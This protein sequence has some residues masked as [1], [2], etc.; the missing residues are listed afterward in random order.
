MRSVL[1]FN[2]QAGTADRIKD[3]LLHLTSGTRCELRPTGS[4]QD[5]RRF[6]REAV[7][8]GI[9]RLI[10]AG[11][12]GTI[13]LAIEGIAPH[14][15][16][17]ELAVLPFGTGNDLARSLGFTPDQMEQAYEAA[18]GPHTV[19]IDIIRI[20]EKEGVQHCINVANGGFGGRVALDV[21]SIDKRRWGP[22]AYWITSASRLVDLQPYEV[23]MELDGQHDEHISSFGVAIANGRFVGGGFPIAPQALLDDGWM[24]ITVIPVLPTIELMVAGL[25]FTLNPQSE[26][27]IRTFRAR[28]LRFDSTPEMPFSVDGEP[29]RHMS[30]TCETLPRV[31]RVVASKE[32]PGLSRTSAGSATESATK[33]ATLPSAEEE[34]DS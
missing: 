23:R 28:R 33:T 29:I 17:I 31:L 24:D 8:E 26:E 3:F 9:D 34:N 22:M 7:E 19:P 10:V 14:F 6:A 16:R 13:G 32:A 12:D 5:A 18:F 25:N 11:G 2:P 4:A 30:F 15:D 21:Q 27:R 1:I 20:T